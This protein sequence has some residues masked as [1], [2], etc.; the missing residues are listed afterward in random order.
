MPIISVHF[1]DINWLFPLP[2]H[3]SVK[4]FFRLA[5]GARVMRLPNPTILPLFKSN[6]MLLKQIILAIIA[7][8]NGQ[9][10]LTLCATFR[11]I[12]C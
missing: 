8:T 11:S 1:Y 2:R 3:P 9:M 4:P 6:S 7:L 12:K 10:G 5:C